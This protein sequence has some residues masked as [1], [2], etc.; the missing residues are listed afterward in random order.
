MNRYRQAI[1]F[2]RQQEAQARKEKAITL[3]LGLIVIVAVLFTA[4]MAGDALIPVPPAELYT[5]I[6]NYLDVDILDFP[7]DAAT[8]GKYLCISMSK[9]L[10]IRD[11]DMIFLINK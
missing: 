5:V 10:F 2:R 4:L 8:C 1:G 3:Y 11:E 9:M 6:D 7:T